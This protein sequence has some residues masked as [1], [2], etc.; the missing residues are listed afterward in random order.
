MRTLV[1]WGI[2]G[3]SPMVAMAAFGATVPATNNLIGVPM[4]PLVTG[5]NMSSAIGAPAGVDGFLKLDVAHS[6]VG[7][8]QNGTLIGFSGATIMDSREVTI[9]WQGGVDMGALPSKSYAQPLIVRNAAATVNL[10]NTAASGNQFTVNPTMYLAAGDDGNMVANA[11]FDVAT[12][13]QW[14][15]YYDQDAVASS[16]QDHTGNNG[17]S[18]KITGTGQGGV[19]HMFVTPGETYK[20][21]FFQKATTSD[22]WME[23][24]FT[25]P[26]GLLDV[27]GNIDWAAFGYDWRSTAPGNTR[28]SY[29]AT[30]EWQEYDVTITPGAGQTDF[31][32]AARNNGQAGSM[33]VDDVYFGLV[34]EPS[35]L[36]LVGLAGALIRRRR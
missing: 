12:S 8:A 23:Y 28:I 19:L 25:N 18:L 6:V 29:A 20:L 13:G 27:W 30:G 9:A 36:A 1:H 32:F 22:G 5:G 33:Y 7:S 31:F 34:P 14:A 35:S 24:G 2:L 26:K 10:T 16:A 21:S 3:L 4:T 17:N 11:R 15:N